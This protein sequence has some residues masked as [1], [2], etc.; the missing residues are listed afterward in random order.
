MEGRNG[1]IAAASRTRPL[2]DVL[3]DSRQVFDQVLAVVRVCP[4]D[5]L[6]DGRRFGLPDDVPP[7]VLVANNTY[8][9]YREHGRAIQAWRD[10]GG[11]FRKLFNFWG[12][13]LMTH[14]PALR[15]P[16]TCSI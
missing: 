11:I 15:H 4:D 7:W 2:R 6:N 8:A 16:P 14:L 5:V 10:L 1:P 9:H 12:V 13:H 3:A